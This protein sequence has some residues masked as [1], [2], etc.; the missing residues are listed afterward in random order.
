MVYVKSTTHITGIKR[1]FSSYSDYLGS[2]D[3]GDKLFSENK[4][5]KV[6]LI[7]YIIFPRTKRMEGGRHGQGRQW[8]QPISVHNPVVET[9]A[10]T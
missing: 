9:Q 7:I 8:S 4:E 2:Y 10:S 1:R 3:T 6:R 5:L